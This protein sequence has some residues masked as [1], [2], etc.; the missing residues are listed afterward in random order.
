MFLTMTRRRN[1]ALLEAAVELH[2]QGA[3]EP[4]T[5]VID[6][7]AVNRNAAALAA[8]ADRHRVELWF[9]AK[10][11]GRNPLITETIARHL[12]WATAIDAREADALLAGGAQLGN[13]GHLVQV[14]RR[15]L[16]SLLARQ[17]SYV[18]VYDTDNLAAVAQAAAAVGIV[19]PVLLK[20]AG[21]PASVYPGQDGGIL[22]DEIERVLAVAN[23]YP[24]VRVA[25]ATGFPCIVFDQAAGTTTG[26]GTLERVLQAGKIL[27]RN[28]LDAKLSLPSHTSV[29]TIPMIAGLGATFGEPGHALTGTTPEHAV[30]PDLAEVPAMVYVSE[31]AQLGTAPSVFGGGFYAR[32]GARSLQVHTAHGTR[33]AQLLDTP[34]ENIDYYRRFEWTEDGPAAHV[35]DTAIMAF[36]TQIFVTR[37]RVAVVSGISTGRPHLDG[38]FDSLGRALP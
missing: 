17:P 31:I 35:G 21:D 27:Q 22:P 13:L 2:T 19:Q 25:G 7:D 33:S 16:P 1:P 34:A 24:S 20:I 37:S 28:G 14:P 12:P 8:A 32:G 10:Q 9:V 5:Y 6:R 11:Y 26:T 30:N 23:R 38:V 3:I 15:R 18:T 36:R 29:S 4:D